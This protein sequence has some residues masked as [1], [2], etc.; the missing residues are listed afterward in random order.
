[1][2]TLAA[3]PYIFVAVAVVALDRWTKNL[4][5]ANIQLY[6][7][8]EVWTGFFRL[9][10]TRNTGIAFSLF[11]DASPFVKEFVLP[12]VGLLAVG[13]IVY[14]FVQTQAGAWF[15]RLSLAFI[16]AGAVGNLYDRVSFGY[17][18]DFLDFYV[19]GHHWPAFNVADSAI[20]VGA[21]MLLLA[22]LRTSQNENAESST[23]E[24]R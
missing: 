23:Q 7:G 16:L 1:M 12:G 6:E 13:F 17:V 4:V 5:I 2:K 3:I 22:S 21:V 24:A 18:T 11:D 8:H 20:S 9:F 15:S 10:H 19:A 14:L